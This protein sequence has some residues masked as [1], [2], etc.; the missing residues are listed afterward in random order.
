[1]DKDEDDFSAPV[2]RSSTHKA[3]TPEKANRNRESESL[4]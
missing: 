3:S 4:F 1:M 2:K